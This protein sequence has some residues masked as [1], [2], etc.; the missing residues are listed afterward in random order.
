MNITV[1]SLTLYEIY[2]HNNIPKWCCIVYA[3]YWSV[4]SMICGI[5]IYLSMHKVPYDYMV[6]ISQLHLY[7]YAHLHNYNCT[8]NTPHMMEFM[9]GLISV[10]THLFYSSKIKRLIWK[11]KYINETQSTVNSVNLIGNTYDR[12]KVFA[13]AVGIK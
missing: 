12:I 1:S 13:V 7:I 11:K 8:V 5:Y 6:N 2:R 3:D 10:H 9:W 4:Y